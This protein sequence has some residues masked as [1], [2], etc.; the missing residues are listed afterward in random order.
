[1][2][3]VTNVVAATLLTLAVPGVFGQ[4]GKTEAAA[5]ATAPAPETIGTVTVNG[6][7]IHLR[8]VYAIRGPAFMDEKKEEIRIILSDVPATVD[9]LISDSAIMSRGLAGKVSGVVARLDMEAN[10]HTGELYHSGF[11][12]LQ[13]ALYGE[14]EFKPTVFDDQRVAGTLFMPEPREFSGYTYHYTA[15]FDVAIQ[16]QADLK[17]QIAAAAATEAANRVPPTAEEAAAAAASGPGQVAS[18]YIKAMLAQDLAALKKLAANPQMFADMEGGFGAMAMGLMADAF[19][20]VQVTRVNQ[21]GDTA[22]VEVEGPALKAPGKIPTVLVKGVWKLADKDGK[23]APEA[24]S[25]SAASDTEGT[26]TPEAAA[27][28]TATEGIGTLTVG[29]KT[30]PLRHAYAFREPSRAISGKEDVRVVLS[31]G[32]ITFVEQEDGFF[33]P[34]EA[35]SSSEEKEAGGR[36]RVEVTFDG[37][38][39]T[40]RYGEIFSGGSEAEF[41]TSEFE[42]TA[43]DDQRVAGRLFVFGNG[44]TI[45][46]VR[47]HYTASFD[48]AIQRSSRKPPTTLTG[49]DAAETGPGKVALAIIKAVQAR[50]LEAV[51]PHLA[52]ADR[53]RLDFLQLELGD[54]FQH[55]FHLREQVTILS[56]TET[57]DEAVVVCEETDENKLKWET[58]LSMVR[59][60]GVWKLTQ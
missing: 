10:A 60:E 28:T 41:I 6:K 16:R 48:A 23:N 30:V 7:A 59:E 42:R 5:Q 34:E 13:M 38:H 55:L 12:R 25:P 11:D 4:A 43:F 50:N 46:G 47:V 21:T 54:F 3:V 49:A 39:K 40:Q 56:V 58:S 26:S 29:E 36:N 19:Q 45:N 52:A 53:R 32:P 24:E 57:G 14:H 2:K 1:M 20:G 15:T 37:E 35:V 18:A 22:I 51:K 8:Y 17:G 44:V 27:Q 31:D 33:V 9:E